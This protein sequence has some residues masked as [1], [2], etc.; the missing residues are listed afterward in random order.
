MNTNTVTELSYARS[1]CKT[2]SLSRL[3]FPKSKTGHRK[4]TFNNIVAQTRKF[5]RGEYIFRVNEPFKTVYAIRTGSVKTYTS[6]EDG[7]DQ[8]TGFH[9]PG[10]L[11]GLDS[12]STN[13]HTDSA[14]ALETSSICKIPF[15]RL[16]S[17]SNKNPAM[18]HALLNAMSEEIQYDH[19]QI[20]MLSRLPAEARL[21]SFLLSVS[22]HFQ[23]RGFSATDFHLSM[24]RSDI[25][26]LLGL[27]VET[28]SRLF[29]LFQEKGLLAVERKHVELFDIEG[30][31]QM[32]PDYCRYTL[33]GYMEQ[34]KAS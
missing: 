7:K 21:A 2:C 9:F 5:E 30:L 29:S 20:T 3:C 28:I 1:G 11:L 26:N 27:A 6:I 4:E 8:I 14:I 24:T 13:Y 18:Q 22:S 34:N 31:M 33:H 32:T 12:I 19:R 23:Q 10:E 25:A 15:E 16:E 17:L